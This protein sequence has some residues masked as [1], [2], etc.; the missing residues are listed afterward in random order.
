M[1]LGFYPGRTPAEVR[2][3]VEAHLAASHARHPGNASLTYSITYQGF[4]AQGCVV[5]IG[6]PA[7]QQL[8]QAH[9]DIAGTDA[10]LNA[11]PATTDVRFFH[12]YGQ[13]PDP[14][15]ATMTA[16]VTKTIE[17][18]TDHA[19]AFN[20]AAKKLGGKA[21]TEVDQV[22]MDEGGCVQQ[23]NCRAKGDDFFKGRAQHVSNEQAKGGADA[24]TASRKQ[25]VKSGAQVRMSFIRL[26]PHSFFN[27]FNFF[28]YR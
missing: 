21:Q 4:Q 3:E 7:I 23:F 1:R 10:P 26:D 25:M 2:A 5:D 13:I 8:L 18:H 27:E 16:F 15:G 14:A 19:G 6:A 17:Q 24:F 9:R 28:C 20:A 22:V 11:T 12:L